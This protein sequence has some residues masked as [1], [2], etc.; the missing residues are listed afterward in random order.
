ML[1]GTALRPQDQVQKL[2]SP[3]LDSPVHLAGFASRIY[4][5][6]PLFCSGYLFTS[7]PSFHFPRKYMEM[8]RGYQKDTIFLK[9]VLEG[10]ENCNVPS[11]PSSYLQ[12]LMH[13]LGLQNDDVMASPF[14]MLTAGL[15][16]K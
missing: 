14:Q 11:L 8:P 6:T 4:C 15:L 9:T 10:F 1:A 2:G 3:G 13:L 16:I 12:S 5:V 7:L